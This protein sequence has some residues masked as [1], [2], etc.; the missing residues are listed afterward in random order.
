LLYVYQLR[1][2]VT[3][4]LKLKISIFFT[5]AVILPVFAV[6]TL[7]LQY[8]RQTEN[9]MMQNLGKMAQTALEKFDSD[10]DHYT[11]NLS[12]QIENLVSRE[13]AA[14]PG[15]LANRRKL[16]EFNK[17][18]FRLARHDEI[19]LGDMYGKDYFSE[20]STR[21]SLNRTLMR[22]AG[23][24]V[25]KILNQEK[26]AA[27]HDNHPHIS[28][29]LFQDMYDKQKIISYLGVGGFELGIYYHL[30]SLPGKT[31]RDLFF[32]G[33][34]WKL[35]TLHRNYVEYHLQQNGQNSALAV[36]S[37]DND[38]L[39]L[40]PFASG[41]RLEHLINLALKN[42]NTE[43]GIVKDHGREYLVAAMPGR[44]LGR[45]GIAAALPTNEVKQEMSRLRRQAVM[46]CLVLVML[47]AGTA[48]MLKDW[49]FSPLQELKS[50]IDAIA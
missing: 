17:S 47:A 29:H 25:L 41:Q 37:K 24:D 48:A 42:N 26:L 15:M 18:L 8:I 28:I 20:I 32:I 4:S 45:L 3:L 35:Q 11:R 36:Y 43:T 27:L 9:E 23:A 44:K 16:V 7:A 33:I 40:S 14:D 10:Y 12:H 49:F 21:V 30:L 31:A 38:H 34:S 39:L 46:L 19:M 13:F 50:G 2:P 6:S 1:H 22:N 5:Y